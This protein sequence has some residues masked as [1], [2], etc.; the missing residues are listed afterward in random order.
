M[1]RA[2]FAKPGNCGSKIPGLRRERAPNP[3]YDL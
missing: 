2:L 3:G 1:G